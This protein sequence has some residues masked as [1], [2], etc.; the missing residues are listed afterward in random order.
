MVTTPRSLIARLAYLSLLLALL[1]SPPLVHA[2]V[3]DVLRENRDIDKICSTSA[4]RLSSTYGQNLEQL[5]RSLVDSISSTGFYNTSIGESPYTAYGLAQCRGDVPADICRNCTAVA[6]ERVK[7]LCPNNTSAMIWLEPCF[8]RFSNTRFFGVLDRRKGILWRDPNSTISGDFD[9]KAL[10]YPLVKEAANSPKM[11]ATKIEQQV[12]Y[13]SYGM[14]YCPRDIT[15]ADCKVCFDDATKQVEANGSLGQV[16]RLLS[17]NCVI[18][19]FT[20][21]FF[22]SSPAPSLPPAPSGNK[23]GHQ[24]RIV[25][26]VCSVVGVILLSIGIFVVLFRRRKREELNEELKRYGS[27]MAS[28]GNLTED[29]RNHE[30]PRYSMKAVQAAT[31]NFSEENKLGGGGFGP[32]Y[33]GELNGRLVAVKRLSEHSKQGLKEFMNEVVLIAKLQHKNLVC[34][35]GC[36]IEQGEKMLIYEYMTNGSLDAFFCDP[37]KRESLD[38]EKR[39]SIIMGSARGIL[40]L[41]QDSRLNII[42]RDLKTGNILLD[43]QMTAKISD[44]GMAR[45][46]SEENDPK[47]TNIIVGTRGYIAPEYAIGGHFSVKSDVYSFGVLLLEIVSGQTYSGF[48]L[49]QMGFTLIGYAWNLWCKGR[50]TDLIDPVLGESAPRSQ[51]IKCVHLGLLCIQEDPASR[52]TMSEIIHMLGSDSQILPSP[53]QPP[54]FFSSTMSNCSDSMT[55]KRDYPISGS[56]NSES[57]SELKCSLR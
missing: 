16:W 55:S 38:W 25:I 35:L 15:P 19:Y 29:E 33:K 14:S 54:L 49:S 39:F 41:H 1:Q 27:E 47:A 24:K 44:F 5:F 31:N 12:G 26:I 36:C 57:L 30:L 21:P 8:I 48:H 42:H 28:L 7:V 40:Y 4:D 2:S 13:T 22:L 11:F 10:M 18:V 32:V 46:F 53:Q 3:E 6:F 17:P 51:I 34:L 9:A 45:I 37:Q 52:P 56:T 20:W 50:V 43:A 23:S